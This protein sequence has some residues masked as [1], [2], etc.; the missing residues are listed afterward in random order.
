VSLGITPLVIKKE[1]GVFAKNVPNQQEQE[2]F[3]NRSLDPSHQLKLDQHEIQ[4][5][6]VDLNA[7]A[8][9]IQQLKSILSADER[10]RA[11]RFHFDHHRDRFIVGRGILRTILSQ[12]LNLP[13]NQLQ[14]QYGSHG[15]PSLIPISDP[16]VQFNLAHSDDLAL[17]AIALQ[18]PVGI[19]LEKIRV[20][21]NVEQLSQRFFAARE[22]QV[23][24]ALPTTKQQTAFFRYWTCKEAYL[25]AI[26]SGLAH[27][28]NQIEIDLSSTLAQ[29]HPLD[30]VTETWSLWELDP[31]PNYA[32]ALVA[33]GCDWQLTY[34]QWSE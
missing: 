32:A 16:A 7:S 17:V 31:A 24:C 23:L 12:Y 25:K 19:D 1:G 27:E 6:R 4:V 11:D 22:H 14:F 5:W 2:L 21:P 28:L 20:M 9:R 18:H 33:K 13:P 10:A 34:W 30:R 8:D 3:H 29:L 26:G 15:K